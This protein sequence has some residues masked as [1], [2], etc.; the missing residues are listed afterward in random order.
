MLREKNISIQKETPILFSHVV[1]R[2]SSY[3]TSFHL[4]DYREIYVY[5][6][7]DVDFVVQENYLSLKPGDIII[8]NRNVMHS[9]IIKSDAPYERFYISIPEDAFAFIDRG[10]RPLSFLTDESC[11]FSL[12]EAAFGQVLALLRRIS[13]L[14]QSDHRPHPYAVYACF[15]QL[16]ECFETA[17]AEED[18]AGRT[19]GAPSLIRE[20]V[21]HIETAA[22]PIG[23]VKELA[24]TFHVNASYLSDLFSK[25]LHVSLKQYLITKKLSEAKRLLQGERSVSEI[26]YECGFSS[27]AHFVAVFK[28]ATGQTPGQYRR[29][30]L[31]N[32]GKL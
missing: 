24:E 16:L 14:L 11:V 31:A 1:D 25:T 28:N 22:V 29:K 8:T 20:V 19:S 27:C 9:P 32:A 15:L 30:T 4:H 6:S 17:E 18:P 12:D 10:E 21:R 26:A 7:G 2:P 13:A 23:S 3:R 5:V